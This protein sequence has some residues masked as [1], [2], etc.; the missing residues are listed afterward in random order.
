MHLIFLLLP[1]MLACHKDEDKGNGA[2]TDDS[3]ETGEGPWRPDVVCPGDEGCETAD[4][5]LSAGAAAVAITPTCYETWDDADGNGE[6]NSSTESYYD[7]GCDHLCEGD[8]GYPGPDEGEGDGEFQAIWMAGFQNS[9]PANGIHDDLWARTVALRQGDTT[10]TI[11]ALDLV[12]FFNDQVDT[13]RDAVAEAGIDVDHVIIVSTHVH[14]GPDTMGMWGKTAFQSG[15]DPQYLAYVRSQAVESISEAVAD[16]QPATLRV[17]KADTSKTSDEKGTR[18]LIR[19][20]R[21][22]VIIDE[23]LYAAQLDS[24]SGDPIATLVNWGNH[25][26]SLSDENV[27]LTSD[28]VHYVRE[29]VEDGVDYDSYTVAGKGGVCVYLNASVGGLMTPLQVH[30]TDGDGN[31]YDQSDFD[32][33]AA[34]GHVVGEQAIRAIDDGQDASNPSLSVKMMRFKLPIDNYGFQALALAGVFDRETYDWNPNQDIDEDNKPWLQTE[35]DLVTLG[36]IQMLTIPG[37]LFPELAIG[38]YDGSHVNTTADVFIDT[39]NPNPPD[40]SQAPDPPYFKDL[41]S[42]DYN[43]ILGLGNDEIGYIVPSYDFKLSD[44]APYLEEADGD[45]YEETNSIGPET[46]DRVSAAVSQLLAWEP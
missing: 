12:G 4:G 7:C 17:G 42:G 5:A 2:G 39:G 29:S 41:M 46:A 1:S 18:N 28:F 31:T 23:W 10:I 26:E 6:Y 43:L 9:R 33:A 8:D 24:T 20:S 44:V 22:P 14:E 32:K 34:I 3:A 37:E 25:P 38:G 11:T 19:D 35:V 36:P 21:D 13:I 30:V 15:I 45:H 16:L 40:V 27:L